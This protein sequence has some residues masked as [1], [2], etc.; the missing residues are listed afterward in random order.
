[1]LL[2]IL[3]A[4]FICFA[5]L[6]YC[7]KILP[8]DQGKEFAVGGAQSAGKYTGSGIIVISAFVLTAVLLIP[9][10]IELIIYLAAIYLSMLSGFLDDSAKI[11]WGRVKKGLLDLFIAVGASAACYYFNGSTISIMTLDVTLTIPPVLYILLGAALIWGSINVTNCS[12]GVDGLCGTL[13]LISLAT[14]LIVGSSAFDMPFAHLIIAFMLCIIAYL[15]YNSNPSTML[16]GDAGSRPIGV[17]LAV[18]MM[19]TGMPVLYLAVCF[20]LIVDGGASL[21]KISCIRFLR[22]KDFMKDIRTPIH[23]HLKKNLEWSPTQVVTRL[24][25]IQIVISFAVVV[26]V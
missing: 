22:M 3:A 26:L 11:P 13:S 6:R 1:M 23:D 15:W 16:M 24:A 25:I 21:L 5:G 2:L 8:H 4:F 17:L 18:M 7:R 14:G 19:K 20:M 10:D 12:D 9:L